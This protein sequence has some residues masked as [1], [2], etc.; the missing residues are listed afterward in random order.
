MFENVLSQ[1]E[2][3]RDLRRGFESGD[4]PGSIVFEGP[5]Y[6]G[7]TTTALE[8]ARALCCTEG[9]AMWNCACRSCASHRILAQS[10]LKLIGPGCFVQ[11]VSAS[12][13]VLRRVPS[14]ASRY[15]FIRAV[16][17]LMLRLDDDLTDESNKKAKSVRGSIDSMHELLGPIAPPFRDEKAKVDEAFIERIIET[18]A[19]LSE[20][21]PTDTILVAVRLSRRS[22]MELTFSVSTGASSGLVNRHCPPPASAI[23]TAPSWRFIAI[24]LTLAP[25]PG[26]C[27]RVAS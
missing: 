7:K 6:S 13:D 23:S 11:E 26:S 4:I 25:P 21:V 15:L 8:L 12:A 3:I 16:R 10:D 22:R 9:T 20:A 27:H 17:K 5:R 24:R 1:D 18:S 19:K 14:A 2:V